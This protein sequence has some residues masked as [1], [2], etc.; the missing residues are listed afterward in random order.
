MTTFDVAVV[1]AGPAGSVAALVLARAGRRVLLLDRERLS[2]HKVG[3]ALPAAARPLLKNL[4]LLAVVEAGP[5]LP[6]YGNLSAWGS[7]RLTA[8]DFIRDPQGLGWHL[9]RAVFDADLRRTAVV[10]GAKW[11]AGTVRQVERDVEGWKLGGAFAEVKAQWLVDATGRGASLARRQGAKTHAK[12]DLEALYAFAEPAP[13]DADC[14]TLIE[15]TKDGW[16]YT[17][18]LPGDRRIVVLHTARARA[19][20]LAANPAAYAGQLANTLHVSRLFAAAR[21]LGPPRRAAAHGAALDQPCGDHWLATG[22]AA[23]AF[24]PLSS[25]GIFNALY[26]GWR[27]GEAVHQ[28]LAGESALLLAYGERLALVGKTYDQHRTNFYGAE[29][30]WPDAPFWKGRAAG[31]Q[32]TPNYATISED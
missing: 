14:R 19:A 16:W 1:G 7:D 27:A 28:A 12:D 2:R 10:A 25:Q 32:I 18:R 30:R 17:A 29:R 22:D 21:F 4:G 24:D 11:Q 23:L 15:A 26:S 31:K 5:H 8:T 9:D 13:G 6:A 3:E 20:H